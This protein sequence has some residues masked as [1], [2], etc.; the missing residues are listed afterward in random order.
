MDDVLI[1]PAQLEA[2]QDALHAGA[3]EAS[4]A[5]GTWID[6][7]AR[8]ELDAV[9]QVP[10]H[11]ATSALGDAEEPVCFCAVGLEGALGGCMI[12]AFDDRSGLTLADLLMDKPPGSAS[13]WGD[14]ERS[15]AEETANIVFCAYLNALSRAMRADLM[16]TPPRFARDYPS[17]LL[18]FAL[19]DQAVAGDRV[20]F[21]R[22]QFHIDETAVDWKLLFVPDAASMATLRDAFPGGQAQ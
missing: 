18:E 8:I 5:L 16:P 21:G 10:L 7:P 13:E 14:M 9:E 6:R 12:L 2:I 17:S 19:M 20:M 11:D 4:T 1:P 22:T 15:A 3:A